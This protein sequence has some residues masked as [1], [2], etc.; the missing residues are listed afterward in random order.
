[1][2][3]PETLTLNSSHPLFTSSS[4]PYPFVHVHRLDMDNLILAQPEST[5]NKCN[6]DQL[7]VTGGAPIPAICGTNT[8]QHSKINNA[9]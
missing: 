7:I 3:W 2:E 1:M 4:Y 6:S 8:G 5:D 9:V